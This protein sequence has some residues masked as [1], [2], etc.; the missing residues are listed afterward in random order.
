MGW[1][2]FCKWGRWVR[3]QEHRVLRL[4]LP[5]TKALVSQAF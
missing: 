1:V 4:S 5:D 3:R 2:A